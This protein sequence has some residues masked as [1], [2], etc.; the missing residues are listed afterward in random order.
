MVVERLPDQVVLDHVCVQASIPVQID[1]LLGELNSS[2]GVFCAP[3]WSARADGW[4]LLRYLRGASAGPLTGA[5]ALSA[6]AL[7]LRDR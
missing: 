5:G 7:V 6:S 2:C 1:D 3:L 4:S